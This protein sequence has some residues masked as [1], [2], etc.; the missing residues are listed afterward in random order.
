VFTVLSVCNEVA[1]KQGEWLNEFYPHGVNVKY[2]GVSHLVTP[3]MPSTPKESAQKRVLARA[4][5]E[6][7]EIG[8]FCNEVARKQGEWLNEFYPHGGTGA[9]QFRN[10]EVLNLN[11]CNTRYQ[12]GNS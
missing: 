3:Q 9:N 11:L 4:T 2:R 5:E 12:N 7:Q 1:R 10:A 8:R 6:Q